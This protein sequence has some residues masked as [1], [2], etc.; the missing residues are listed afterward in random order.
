MRAH[1]C[2]SHSGCGQCG[3]G[4]AVSG[5][6]R[7]RGS[8]HCRP[9]ILSPRRHPPAPSLHEQCGPQPSRG[10][11]LLPAPTVPLDVASRG[12]ATVTTSLG[13]HPDEHGS[14]TRHPVVTL[15]AGENEWW[16]IVNSAPFDPAKTWLCQHREHG[17]LV[18]QATLQH[19][20]GQVP[21]VP[22]PLPP[23]PAPRYTGFRM[24]IFTCKG[25]Q[26]STQTSPP[27]KQLEVISGVHPPVHGLYSLR[28]GMTPVPTTP[29]HQP[30]EKNAHKATR[31]PITPACKAALR[32]SH[33]HP[34]A[35]SLHLQHGPA[36]TS[37][38]A[39]QPAPVVPLDDASC[40]VAA[41]TTPFDV[42]PANNRAR[43]PPP[44]APSL[45]KHSV[46]EEGC[47]RHH[48]NIPQSAHQLC[49]RKPPK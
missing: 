11:P 12:V 15:T 7:S 23:T 6:C 29:H 17:S 35:P 40:C 46:W 25:A 34:P 49:C 9:A 30:A 3:T 2:Q 10:S 18:P 45:G 20:C 4:L 33:S 47:A 37:G 39:L 28:R 38:R 44:Q 22:Q 1:A 36:L 14:T 41:I 19:V 27:Q 26:G 8:V 42:G 13:A 31:G 21:S 48:R 24:V 16:T 5:T 32:P 43:Q